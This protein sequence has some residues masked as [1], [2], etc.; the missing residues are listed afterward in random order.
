MWFKR[1]WRVIVGAAMCA[2]LVLLGGVIIGYIL[3]SC[4][5]W[6]QLAT[7]YAMAFGGAALIG[8]Q[9]DKP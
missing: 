8:S 2:P 6:V 9:P 5:V 4:P 7:V 1:Y 3:W